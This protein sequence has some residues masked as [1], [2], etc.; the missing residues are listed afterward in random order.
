MLGMSQAESF[1]RQA[2]RTQKFTLGA[3]R[4]YT[5]T[6]DGS[7]V[8]F[9]RSRAGDDRTTCLWV[10]D[11]DGEVTAER[12]VADPNAL[13]AGGDEELSA[14]ERARR[15][16]TRTGAAGIVQYATDEAVTTAAFPL[17]S[18]RSEERRVGKECRSRWSPY[19]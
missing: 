3:P 10:L 12:L 9:L 19:H 13:L 7:R 18:R 6:P 4:A 1:P 15:E 5:I 11:L 17:S 16:R 8:V 14:Q 2:A